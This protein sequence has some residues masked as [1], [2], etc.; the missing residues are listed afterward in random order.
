LHCID[1]PFGPPTVT[2]EGEVKACSFLRDSKAGIN[3]TG[4]ITSYAAAQLESQFHIG[5][6][7]ILIVWLHKMGQDGSSVAAAK[8]TA[9]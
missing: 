3:T 2:D 5:I 4:Q 8:K 9:F 1:D 7:S 6:Y